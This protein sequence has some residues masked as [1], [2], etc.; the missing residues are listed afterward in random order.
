MTGSTAWVTQIPE[1]SDLADYHI[2]GEPVTSGI[3]YVYLYRQ[4]GRVKAQTLERK[5]GSELVEYSAQ[6]PVL[7]TFNTFYYPGWHAYLLD[8]ETNA[9]VEELPI[10]L[11]GELGLITVRVPEGVGRVLLQFEDTPV[12]KLGTAVSL[13]SLLLVALLVLAGL[14]LRLKRPPAERLP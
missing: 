7:I 3:N 9:V 5:V 2:A 4:P 6:R 11:R 10:S 8:A 14:L 13:A 1:W 12:R